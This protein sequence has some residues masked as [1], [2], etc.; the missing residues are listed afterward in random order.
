MNDVVYVSSFVNDGA[1][2]SELLDMAAVLG[3]TVA[4]DVF[5]PVIGDS[6]LSFVEAKAV[7]VDIGRKV[8]A[9]LNISE[10]D[11]RTNVETATLIAS[12]VVNSEVVVNRASIPADVVAMVS[13]DGGRSLVVADVFFSHM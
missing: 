1:I 5:I 12:L 13:G 10:F 4:G 11:V 7:V 9:V 3:V 8:V 6:P 2:I